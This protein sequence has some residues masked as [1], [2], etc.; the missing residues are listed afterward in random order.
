[1]GTHDDA[2]EHS[3]FPA[4]WMITRATVSSIVIDTLGRDVFNVG[5]VLQLT[6]PAVNVW[7]MKKMLSPVTT[8]PLGREGGGNSDSTMSMG[9]NSGAMMIILIIAV[10]TGWWYLC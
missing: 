1:M 6:R 4:Q 3:S 10:T 9:R 8:P 5:Q 7:P 2:T